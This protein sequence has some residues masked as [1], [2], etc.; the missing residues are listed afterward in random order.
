M[1]TK[2]IEK[3]AEQMFKDFAMRRTGMWLDWRYLSSERRLAWV[4]EVSENL[5]ECLNILEKDLTPK[6]IAK[7][8]VMGGYERGWVV[9]Q[10][11]E[12]NRIKLRIEAMQEQIKS[13]VEA[14]IEKEAEKDAD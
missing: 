10:E 12:W 7:M 4:K 11:Q 14:F 8:P 3:I 9:G 1:F 5:T 13:Q 6:P 2:P